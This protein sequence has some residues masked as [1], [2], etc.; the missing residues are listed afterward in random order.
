M[1]ETPHK[2][3][4]NAMV[5]DSTDAVIV[6]ILEH[7][8]RATLTRLAKASGLSVSAVQSRVQK[9]ERKGVIT[10][11]RALIDYERRG[12]PVSAFV[13]VTPLDFGQEAT[14]PN[15]LRD[16]PGIEACYSITG[17]PSFM[18]VVRVATPSK[19]EELINTIHRIVPVSTETTMVL[20]T[21]FD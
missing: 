16:I 11:Y 19:L 8:G 5:M 4:N 17:S 12:L 10:G 20:Q 9:L 13:S 7:D 1:T 15:K 21:Y 18:L 3:E 14:I 2:V 6:D